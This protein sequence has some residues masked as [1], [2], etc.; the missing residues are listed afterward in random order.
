MSV[1][2]WSGGLWNV[3]RSV[4]CK[5]GIVLLGFCCVTRTGKSRVLCR[6]VHSVAVQCTVGKC[7][8]CCV[9][10]VLYS[11]HCAV[12]SVQCTVFSVWFVLIVVCVV[13][14]AVCVVQ[15]TVCSVQCSVSGLGCEVCSIW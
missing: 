13:Q 4:K 15:C 7:A 5:A 11:E 12:Y 10:C 2:E 14:C 8:G 6:V 3:F 1:P 9:Q